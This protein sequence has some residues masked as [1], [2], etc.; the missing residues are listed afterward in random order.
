MLRA[1][2]RLAK[3]GIVYGNLLAAGAGFMLAAKGSINWQLLVVFLAGIALVMASA[4]V[5]NNI[6]DRNIDKKMKRT[7]LRATVT[8]EISL[9]NAAIYATILCVGGLW[10]LMQVSW[11]VFW[12]GVIAY[13]MYVVV[14]GIAKRGS[15]YGTLV[16]AIPGAMPP[17]AGYTAVSG[18]LDMGSWLL[19]LIMIAWQMPHFYAI[20]IFRRKEYE[21]AHIP[22]L[23]V[24]R[25][26]A[27]TKYHMAL[28]VSL[29]AILTLLLSYFGY[30]GVVF[31]IIMTTLSF[32][33]L[34]KIRRGIRAKDNEK[35]ARGVFGYSLKVLLVFCVMLSIEAWIL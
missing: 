25:G 27:S 24:V 9:R 11:L 29:F 17:M 32:I 33:W 23:S 26:V 13:I 2:Y 7:K 16:G 4:C 18:G 3:P 21:A 35:W 10:L 5:S 8:G 6:I 19:F 34:F 20:A 12:L 30:T 15:V 22:V 28:Y 14:Y 31:A 1:Y